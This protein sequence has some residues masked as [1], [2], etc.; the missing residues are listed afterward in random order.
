MMVKENA[1][2]KGISIKVNIDKG[3]NSVLTDEKNQA[4]N[5]SAFG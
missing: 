5:V 3:I 1:E 4:D 2:K